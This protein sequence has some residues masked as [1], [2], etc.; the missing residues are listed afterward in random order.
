MSESIEVYLEFSRLPIDFFSGAAWVFFIL[1]VLSCFGLLLPL[2]LKK[3]YN[4]PVEVIWDLD[5]NGRNA[6]EWT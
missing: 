3:I 5:S 6:S 2:N 1:K 4:W